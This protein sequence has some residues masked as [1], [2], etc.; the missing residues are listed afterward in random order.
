MMSGSEGSKI[1]IILII[2]GKL[3]I[4]NEGGLNNSGFLLSFNTNLKRL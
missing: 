2:E 3:S 1:I 4:S